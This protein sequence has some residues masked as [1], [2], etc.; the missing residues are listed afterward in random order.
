MADSKITQLPLSPYALDKDLMVVV[1]GHLEEGAYPYNTRMPLSYIRR[2]VVRLNLMTVPTSGISTYYNSGLNVLTL[3][4]TPVTGNLMRYDY[5][6]GF[7]HDQ[8]IS[9]TGLNAIVG[10][11]IDIA[12]KSD[13][14]AAQSMN[15]GAAGNTWDNNFN[16]THLGPP[17]HSG[18]ISIT[19]VNARTENLIVR[20]YEHI[21]PFTGIYYNTGVNY[22]AGNSVDLIF[23]KSSNA[24]VAMSTRPGSWRSDFQTNYL[25]NKYV[26]GLISITGLNAFSGHPYGNLIRVDYDSVWP[27]S[28]II[29]QTGLNVIRG[30]LIDITYDSTSAAATKM[31]SSDGAWDNNFNKNNHLGSPYHSGIIA[32]TGLNVEGDGGNR[33][34]YTIESDW[35]YKYNINATGLNI[36]KGN[37]FSNAL[38]GIAYNIEPDNHNQY[39]LFSLDKIKHYS[40]NQT[41]TVDSGTRTTKYFLDAGALISYCNIKR[42]K[43]SD[44]LTVLAELGVRL[45]DDCVTVTVP[46]VADSGSNNSRK[47]TELGSITGTVVTI[48]G[49]TDAAN[50]DTQEWDPWQLTIDNSNNPVS[51]EI[52]I[53]GNNKT[54]L[55]AQP[56]KFETT[57]DKQLG[58]AG[59]SQP[60]GGST[61]FGTD[62]Y[63]HEKYRGTTH[64][65]NTGVRHL[66]GDIGTSLTAN[67][68]TP[69]YDYTAD[70]FTLGANKTMTLKGTVEPSIT[71][72]TY[73]VN[74]CVGIRYGLT[75]P[76]YTRQYRKHLGQATANAD[77]FTI[78]EEVFR[79][80]DVSLPAVATWTINNTRYLKC[81][82]MEQ[83]PEISFTTQP[84][85]F[86]STDGNA[87]FTGVAVMSDYTDPYYQ[88]EVAN[89]GSSSYVSVTSSNNSVL[90]LTGKNFNNDNG[91]KYRVKVIAYDGTT[92]ATSDAATLT[93]QPP[94]LTMTN[95]SDQVRA[96]DGTATFTASASANLLGTTIAY[97]WELSTNNEASYSTIS[98]ATGTVLN[99]SSLASADDGNHYRLTASAAG[100]SGVQSTGAELHV[101]NISILEQPSGL[102]VER[103]SGSFSVTANALKGSGTASPY[104]LYYVWQRSTNSGVSFF[105]LGQ[106]GTGLATVNLTNLTYAS[107]DQDQYRVKVRLQ[108]F[109]DDVEEISTGSSTSGALL[110]VRELTFSA[111]PDDHTING[112]D[113]LTPSANQDLVPTTGGAVYL[114]SL[115]LARN[116]SATVHY[117][118]QSGNVPTYYYQSPTTWTNISGETSSVLQ[119]SSSNGLLMVENSN[120]AFYRCLVDDSVIGTGTDTA[121]MIRKTSNTAK[122]TPS[123]FTTDS[124][125]TITDNGDFAT[126]ERDGTSTLSETDFMT[127]HFNISSGVGHAVSVDA[128]VGQQAGINFGTGVASGVPPGPTGIARLLAVHP[129]NA[130]SN[131]NLGAGVTYSA[132]DIINI[133]VTGNV[134]QYLARL[135]VPI[136]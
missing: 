118:W 22:I 108:G 113:M 125:V 49:L 111:Q 62:E 13:S 85:S 41:L 23:N 95:P 120:Y 130:T 80:Y 55:D 117:Q 63:I 26:S 73:N 83:S 79:Y 127:F 43:P 90:S 104:P 71:S 116:S 93:V 14:D 6:S 131:A 134:N 76:K 132:G 8:T 7:P 39:D 61:T 69:A 68:I 33:I 38:N 103:G 36:V 18:I 105:N 48:A 70:P 109:G 81:E 100:F 135:N 37:E 60:L 128:N 75:N 106:A 15:G 88:W 78:G 122:V 84:V 124:A 42:H 66:G 24:S 56:I 44:N 59:G 47:T 99:L 35:P 82:N 29:S 112:K 77:G 40:T 98:G 28:G 102:T 31:H 91:D 129:N 54:L 119:I 25:Q 32:V 89:S 5:D 74:G 96:D 121:G 123:T 107:N 17:Y 87:S 27:H 30:N 12:F 94:T 92:T 65:M 136:P 114:D 67:Q 101:I 110:T 64:L 19:G 11:N 72:S 50:T 34:V 21:W 52:T 51:L 20:D 46:T 86:Q 115:A 1:T 45:D 9:T 16:T 133:Q 58:T 3:Q 126:V 53:S 4:H 2:Y 57:I 10:N 97:Q